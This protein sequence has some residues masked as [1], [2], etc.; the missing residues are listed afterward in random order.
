M[1]I[2]RIECVPLSLPT[3]MRGKDRFGNILL[4]KIHT[5]EG[6]TGIGDAG[7]VNQEI[8]T[9]MIKSWEPLLIGADP[10]DRGVIFNRISWGIKAVWGV[11][12]PAAVCTVDFALWDLVGKAYNQ[13]VYRLLGGKAVDKLRF[14]FFIH[15]GRTEESRKA[16]VEEAEKAVAAGV[17]SIGLKN[18]GFGGG[19]QDIEAD[20]ANVKAI[21]KAVGDRVEVAFDANASMDFYTALQFA[22]EVEDCNLYKLEQP[23]GA[24]NI[25]GM[26]DLRHMIKIPICSHESTVDTTGLMEVIKKRAA[27]ILGTKLAAAQKVWNGRRLPKNPTWGCTA[28]P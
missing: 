16:A 5:D 28:A 1:K 4:V 27:D 18:A 23:V 14:D 12:Y 10:L 25:D 2:T 13:P 8:V 24:N 9:A 22:R 3:P 26:A 20:I 19:G 17:T 7:G 15:C 11:S 6:I 21:T